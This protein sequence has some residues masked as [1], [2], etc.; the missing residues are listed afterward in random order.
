[1]IDMSSSFNALAVA[2]QFIGWAADDPT[3]DTDAEAVGFAWSLSWAQLLDAL[4]FLDDRERVYL[5]SRLM[6]EAVR[7]SITEAVEQERRLL[8]S[9]ECLQAGEDCRGEVQMHSPPGRSD[10]RVF[11]RCQHHIAMVEADWDDRVARQATY[12]EVSPPS[13]FDPLDAGED[14]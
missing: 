9:L 7:D 13:W 11:P 6:R 1:M 4:D 10:G 14:W 5:I 8:P 3:V 2:R 12:T